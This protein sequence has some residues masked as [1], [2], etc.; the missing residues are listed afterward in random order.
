MSGK[1]DKE[2][3]LFLITGLILLIS[4]AWK[5]YMLAYVLKTGARQWSYIPFQLC[6]LPMY[7]CILIWIFRKHGFREHCL[8]FLSDFSLLSGMAAFLDSSGMHYGY[9]LLTVHSF[10]WHIAIIAIGLYSGLILRKRSVGD[11][12]PAAGIYLAG[13]M[14]AE[15]VNFIFD[16]RGAVNM[17]YIN[18]HYYME[19]I[20][21]R[22][23]LGILPNNWVILIYILVTVLGAFL[24]HLC[25]M[26]ADR[27][28]K[29]VKA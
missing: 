3:I 6:S 2:N 28:R 24:V 18:P 25:W 13:C 19:Q 1:R 7:L 29:A 27:M 4:E 9:A 23:L 10:I 20:V 22:S 17:F 16:S 11:F 14:L 15:A 5:Q 21:F 12:L 26:G 8:N